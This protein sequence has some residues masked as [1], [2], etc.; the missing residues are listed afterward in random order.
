MPV[1]S[2]TLSCPI[3]EPMIAGPISTAMRF[4]ASWLRSQRGHLSTP[5]RSSAGTWMATWST[6]PTNTPIAS[7]ST[8]VLKCGEIQ[9]AKMIITM[10]STTDENAGSA[11][12]W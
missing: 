5:R 2:I 3:D 11:N 1:L 10:F 7:A 6:P 4:T 12:F 9:A 8:G